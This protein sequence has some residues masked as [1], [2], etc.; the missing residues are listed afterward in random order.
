MADGTMYD[1]PVQRRAMAL[2]R[3][4]EGGPP[5][6]AQQQRP[7]RCL[8]P[9]ELARLSP[10]ERRALNLQLEREPLTNE[11]VAANLAY[12]QKAGWLK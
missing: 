11:E 12:A 5:A 6:P 10:I 2:Q 7:P 3:A 1:S 4:R 8:S 9:D